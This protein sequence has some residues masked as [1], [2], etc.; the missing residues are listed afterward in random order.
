MPLRPPFHKQE[1]PASCLPACLRMIFASYGLVIEEAEIRKACDCTL[2]GAY[3]LNAVDAA[4]AFGFI[5]TNKHTL[6]FRDLLRVVTDGAN[7]IVLVSLKPI[8]GIRQTHAVIVVDATENS[9]T[10]LD[11]MKGERALATTV[12]RAAWALQHSIAIII[13]R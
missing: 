5:G 4:R 1:T 3:A 12:F 7:P 8:D 13:A 2:F 10:V 6:S 11:P 9:V